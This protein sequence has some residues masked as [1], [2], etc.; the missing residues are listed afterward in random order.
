MPDN[1]IRNQ[2]LDITPSNYVP[3]NDGYDLPDEY[4]TPVAENV[5]ATKKKKRVKSP[6]NQFLKNLKD[7]KRSKSIKKDFIKMNKV[8]AIE[9][10]DVVIYTD[11]SKIPP[12]PSTQEDTDDTI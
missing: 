7:R 2:D 3:S 4:V 9:N 10:V 8:K 5:R 6:I 11:K 12:Q 1:K